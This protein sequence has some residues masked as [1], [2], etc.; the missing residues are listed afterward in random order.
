MEELV[1][2]LTSTLSSLGVES[3]SLGAAVAALVA[4]LA[5]WLALEVVCRRRSCAATPRDASP[6]GPRR[7][8][9]GLG[10]LGLGVLLLGL[11]GVAGLDGLALESE[12]RWL[13]QRAQARNGLSVTFKAAAGSLLLGDARLQGVRMTGTLPSGS[14]IDLTAE[15][16]D[17]KTPST[18][19]LTIDLFR[20]HDAV[21]MVTNR[22]GDAV[23]R[24]VRLTVDEME[25]R[26]LRRSTVL[27]DTLFR[28]SARGKIE[29]GPLELGS[30]GGKGSWKISGLGVDVLGGLSGAPLSW[31]TEGTVDLDVTSTFGESGSSEVEM[32]W[33]VALRGLTVQMPSAPPAVLRP[34]ADTVTRYL[35]RKGENVSLSFPVTLRRG[36][37]EGAAS[38]DAAGLGKAVREKL[39]EASRRKAGEGVSRVRGWTRQ[40]K[41]R[42][43]GGGG[44]R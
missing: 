32:H 3:G 2:I 17:E 35:T 36:Q 20:I 34:V 29:E 4:A 15:A 38:I 26:A 12:L 22:R 30:A 40:L 14:R 24:P 21:V 18:R 37:I 31:I 7:W 25:C 5:L 39:I 41:E 11:V 27:F 16:V 43:S 10:L 33:N 8:V 19:E 23:S 44:G 9:R 42:L 28:S 1:A 13:L 6:G